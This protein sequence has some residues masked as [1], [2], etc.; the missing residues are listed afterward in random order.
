MSPTERLLQHAFDHR[1]DALEQARAHTAECKRKADVADTLARAINAMPSR[2][3]H[4][5]LK[6]RHAEAVA[7][8]TEA[9]S[10]LGFDEYA[11]VGRIE[12]FL[13]GRPEL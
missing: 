1:L 12:T 10:A 9:A 11:L 6:A 8:L 2:A 5:A 4:D 7:L 13:R 3:E